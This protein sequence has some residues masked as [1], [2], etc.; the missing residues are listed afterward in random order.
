MAAPIID[1][2]VA[3]HLTAARTE[4]D[5]RTNAKILDGRPVRGRVGDRIRRAMADLGVTP[6][7]PTAKTA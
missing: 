6:P 1:R 7:E 3:I 4:A 2:H 5:P